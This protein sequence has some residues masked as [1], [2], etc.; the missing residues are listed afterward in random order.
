MRQAPGFVAVSR[1][2]GTSVS[3]VDSGAAVWELLANPRTIDEIAHT[4]AHT[5]AAAPAVIAS[6]IEPLL[7]QLA[8]TG[9][10]TTD[11]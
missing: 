8:E 6:D 7:T 5:Y 10:V 3:L 1:V 9:F 2:D 4:L 11:E